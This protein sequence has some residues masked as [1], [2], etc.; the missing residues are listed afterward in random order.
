MAAIRCYF[1]IS[2]KNNKIIKKWKLEMVYDFDMPLNF[3]TQWVKV[4]TCL[5]RTIM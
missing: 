4:L 2:N 1:G 5:I 3:G